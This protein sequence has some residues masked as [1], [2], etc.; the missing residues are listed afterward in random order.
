MIRCNQF[1]PPVFFYC[2]PKS[3]VERDIIKNKGYQP[4][5]SDLLF[6]YFRD[7]IVFLDV[8]ENIEFF[9]I[10]AAEQYPGMSVH[11]FEPHQSIYA[12]LQRNIDLN[13]NP[14]NLEIFPFALSNFSG[15][16]TLYTA[17]QE[18]FNQGVSSLGADMDGVR[19]DIS[20]NVQVRQIDEIYENS[21]RPLSVIKIDVQGFEPEELRQ[22]KGQYAVFDQSLFSSITTNYSSRLRMRGL[23]KIYSRHF[24]EN[25][26]TVYSTCHYSAQVF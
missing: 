18:D 14:S 20:Q 22:G 15:S 7:E 25:R 26:V 5:I 2:D 12:R 16:T 23:R 24:S 10:V 6:D 4:Q 11:A 1:S 21:I 8:G 13:H 19:N 9:S 17:S 3:K